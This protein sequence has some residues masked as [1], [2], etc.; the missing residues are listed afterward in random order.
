[1]FMRAQIVP[2]TAIALISANSSG[3]AS[4]YKVD[5]AGMCGDAMTAALPPSALLA[6]FSVPT[7]SFVFPHYNLDVTVEGKYFRLTFSPLG[8]SEVRVFWFE[9]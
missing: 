3:Q 6:D 5:T 1:M 7:S 9:H 4:A 8:E 2:L